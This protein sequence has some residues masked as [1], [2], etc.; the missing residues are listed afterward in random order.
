MD[1]SSLFTL[2]NM[3]GKKKGHVGPKPVGASA[4]KEPSQ[5]AA[6]GAGTG[7]SKGEGALKKKNGG[8]RIEPPTK[9]LKAVTSGKE[10]ASDI[11][12]IVDE[13]HASGPIPQECAHQYF[14]GREK[15]EAIVPKGAS[16][17]EGNLVPSALMSQM[18]PSADRL[19]LVG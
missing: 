4:R 3:K 17:L 6:A 19:A 1:V 7:S 16:I 13:G 2:K 18:V 15:L 5:T 8:K 9:K 14:F 10:P 12:I 11:V